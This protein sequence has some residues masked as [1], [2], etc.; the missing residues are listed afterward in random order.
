MTQK[1]MDNQLTYPL[2]ALRGITVFPGMILHFDLNRKKSIAAVNAAM[3]NNQEV[4]VSCQRQAD[5]D[6]PGMDDLYPEG[7]IVEIKQVTKLP[8]NLMRVLV[9]GKMRASIE[10]L[11]ICTNKYYT[12]VVSP[13]DETKTGLEE[14]EEVAMLRVTMEIVTSYLEHFPRIAKTLQPQIQGSLSLAQM[15]DRVAA[16][17]PIPYEKKQQIL[18][19]YDLKERFETINK[20]LLEEIDIAGI[21]EKLAE[22]IKNKVEKNQ[23]DYIL[24]E[25]L[26]YIRSEL[27]GN[28]SLTETELFLQ[29]VDELNASEEIK[30]KIRKEINRYEVISN[31]SSESAVERTYIETL[32]EM[33]WDNISEDNTDLLHAKEVLERNHYGMDKIK[34]RILEFLAVRQMVEIR[35]MSDR[36]ETPIICLVGPP[37][38]GKT[39]IAKS[40]AQSLGK[41]YQRICLGGVRDEAEIRG[42]RRTYVGAMMGQVAS[43]LRHAKVKNPLILLDEID[44]VSN[45]YKGDTFSALLEVLDPDQNKH[46]RD[47]YVELPLDLSQVLFIATANTTS[48]IPRPLL[49]RMEVIEVSGY[50]EN[51]KFHIAKDHLL[52]K[53]LLANGMEK[54]RLKIA[55]KALKDIIRYYTREAGVREL[56][57][58]IGT[59]CRKAAREYL[60]NDR[61]NRKVSSANL[62]DYLGKRIYTLQMANKRNEVGIV[63]GLAWTQVGG[64]TLQI[65]VNVMPGKGEI[66]LTGQ[67][68]DVMQE[69]AVIG[70]SYI[71]S[72]SAKYK[73]SQDVFKKNDIHIHIP[74]GAVPKDGPSAG[75]TMATAMLSAFTKK[76]VDCK[77][78]MTGEI[79]LRGKV[80]P[81]GGL[82]E[83][84]LAAKTAGIKKVLVPDENKKDIEEIST[85]ITDGLE[86]VYVT[87]MEEVLTHALI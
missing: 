5:I 61:E 87:T 75:I 18:A 76:K 21:R 31:S 9:E 12:A 39:S 6:E 40:V 83:K 70:L 35:Q 1:K 36:G 2:I 34:E 56:E 84:L 73:I 30:E 71:R 43:A 15:I 49:D 52:K 64:D 74:E 63:R 14:N 38:T 46:F 33:P 58:K 20:I 42:H 77:L 7:T 44:K 57:R 54:G 50:T 86:I 26:S 23:R 72:V 10:G 48:T 19:A 25:Q 17:I 68:G 80:L 3:S 22:E 27:N 60:E 4:I 11:D 32:L 41:E 13:Y 16:N 81:I 8:G 69:S 24:R 37:G 51:E 67:M 78:A 82:K 45:D 66:V 62:E 47:H 79:T 29:K 85:E 53:Q 59:V 55:D 28:D 65:E